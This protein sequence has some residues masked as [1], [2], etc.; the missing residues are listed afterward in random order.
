[1]RQLYCSK[2]YIVQDLLL[3]RKYY[4]SG[5]NGSCCSRLVLPGHV[6]VLSG[7]RK[8]KAAAAEKAEKRLDMSSASGQP[9]KLQVMS[10]ANL[11]SPADIICL[12]QATLR[13]PSDL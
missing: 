11:E 3:L 2:P 4:C 10:Q 9:A 6:G 8:N 7:C 13:C 1:M 12:N 5:P